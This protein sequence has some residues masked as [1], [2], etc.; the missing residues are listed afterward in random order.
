MTIIKICGDSQYRVK[1]KLKSF[2]L[3][4][5]NIIIITYRPCRDFQPGQGSILRNFLWAEVLN[6]PNLTYRGFNYGKT[7]YTKP[8]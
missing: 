3:C 1:F 2:L 5:L 7:F 4:E 8:S 6:E